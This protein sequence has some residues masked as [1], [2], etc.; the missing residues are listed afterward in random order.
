M[1][2]VVDNASIFYFDENDPF[3]SNEYLLRLFKLQRGYSIAAGIPGHYLNANSDPEQ[4]AV[5]VIEAP[6]V[7]TFV[8]EGLPAKLCIAFRK[9]GG[10]KI[11]AK[12]LEMPLQISAGGEDKE[13][14]FYKW[15]EA[16]SVKLDVIKSFIPLARSDGYNMVKNYETWIKKAPSPMPF[17]EIKLLTLKDFRAW[18]S[19]GRYSS[20][21]IDAVCNAAT[22]RARKQV[23]EASGAESAAKR[24]STSAAAQQAQSVELEEVERRVKVI[25]VCR[26]HMQTLAPFYDAPIGARLIECALPPPEQD[27]AVDISALKGIIARESNEENKKK[28]FA[29]LEKQEIVRL[30]SAGEVGKLPFSSPFLVNPPTAASSSGAPKDPYEEA[31]KELETSDSE[32]DEPPPVAKS[33]EPVAKSADTSQCI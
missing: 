8:D 28:L 24:P 20:K 33:D 10:T 4:S 23:K 9:Y 16:G 30:V 17:R 22:V 26:A 25:E 12:A 2:L 19:A 11:C 13:P 29:V 14:K 1:D 27:G 15:K 21:N 32:S 31:R 3:G 18:L 6:C 7:L 5:D